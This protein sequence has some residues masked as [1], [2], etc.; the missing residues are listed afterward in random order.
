MPTNT[1]SSA[2]TRTADIVATLLAETSIPYAKD[3]AQYVNVKTVRRKLERERTKK[4]I[5][6]LRAYFELRFLSMSALI[7]QHGF[8][9]VFEIA[10]GLSPR[11]LAFSRNFGA[12]Y[13]AT[14][15]ENYQTICDIV[16]S[17]L[18]RE[19]R[20]RERSGEL[21]VMRV[22]ALDPE[23]IAENFLRFKQRIR[24]GG[25]AHDQ[26]IAIIQTGL[27]RYLPTEEKVA[28]LSAIYNVLD[29]E[30][31]FVTTDIHCAD[32]HNRFCHVTG[33]AELARSTGRAIDHGADIFYFADRVEAEAVFQHCGLAVKEAY[34]QLT[35]APGMATGRSPDEFAFLNAHEIWLMQRAS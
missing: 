34:Q 31:Y 26:R 24:K 30:T 7:A 32:V 29:P 5:D 28:E 18:V 19:T 21:T 6:L 27:L 4:Q 20:D 1:A 9:N 35:L 8:S 25:A 2:V 33:S 13:C 14:D 12:H 15:Y 17:I 3:V 23:D 11:G 10:A 22:N 16:R